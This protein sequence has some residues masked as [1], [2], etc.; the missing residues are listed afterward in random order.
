MLLEDFQSKLTIGYKQGVDTLTFIPSLDLDKCKVALLIE[1][2]WDSRS[3]NIAG[4]DFLNFNEIS[5]FGG[6]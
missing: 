3:L 5:Y 2:S 6:N 4:I 1:D